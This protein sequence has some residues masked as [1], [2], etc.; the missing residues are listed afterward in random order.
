MYDLFKRYGKTLKYIDWKNIL[1]IIWGV[2]SKRELIITGFKS[3]E[4]I[5][6]IVNEACKKK[7]VENIRDIKKELLIPT[8]DTS[9][10]KVFVFNSC[11]LDYE[12]KIE[13]FIPRAAIGKVVRASCSFPV[14]FSPCQYEGT[15]L[16][17]GGIKEN[18]P[19]NELKVIGCDK[20]LSINFEN[21][22]QKK[23]CNNIIEIAE[24]SFELINEELKRHETERIDFLHTIKLEEVSLLEIEKMDEIY[25]EGYKQTKEKMSLIKEY[26]QN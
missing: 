1:K 5:E 18:I 12:T 26:F 10:G 23:C 24:R 14:I 13:K 6:K 21:V 3:G 11:N 15:E 2:I 9:S 19:Y 8:I 20:I 22:T 7:N 17:D 4:V 25:K 16:L